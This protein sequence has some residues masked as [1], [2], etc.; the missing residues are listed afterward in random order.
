MANSVANAINTVFKK[1][2][3][4][5]TAVVIAV[6][7]FLVYVF[8]LTNRGAY[9][10]WDWLFSILFAV[11]IGVTI[12]LQVY[13]RKEVKANAKVC[14]SVGTVTGAVTTACAG[15]APVI[16]GWFG[17]GAG[18]FTGLMEGIFKIGSLI[19]LYLALHWTSK[20]IPRGK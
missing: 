17:V 14:S 8:Y 11:L 6:V 2:N 3:Y 16:L 20:S 15:C 13:Y 9:D 7:I 12:T 1:G 18:F 19:L 5:I 4:L 10:V